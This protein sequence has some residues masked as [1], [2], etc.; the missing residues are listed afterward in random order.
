MPMTDTATEQ[1]ES[2]TNPLDTQQ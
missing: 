1:S 2:R